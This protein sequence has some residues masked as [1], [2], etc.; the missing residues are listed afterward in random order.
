MRIISKI[1][2]L[3]TAYKKVEAHD[4]SNKNERSKLQ[5]A[6]GRRGKKASPL[7]D[8][9]DMV[10]KREMRRAQNRL[11]RRDYEELAEDDKYNEMFKD[12]LDRYNEII[13]EAP[14]Q[15]EEEPR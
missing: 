15:F 4:F 11:K 3:D 14:S 6:A 5:S 9:E 7:L 1:L 10:D 8:E 13:Q 2:N 12:P